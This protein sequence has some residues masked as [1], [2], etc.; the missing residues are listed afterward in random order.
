MDVMRYAWSLKFRRPLSFTHHAP[1][2]TIYP[3]FQS[4]PTKFSPHDAAT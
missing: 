3:C 1:S 2:I 4:R